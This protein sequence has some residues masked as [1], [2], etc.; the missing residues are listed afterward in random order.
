MKNE[1]KETS[2]SNMK[3][4]P[5]DALNDWMPRQAYHGFLVGSAQVYLARFFVENKS[6]KGGIDDAIKARDFINQ[7]IDD[8]HNNPLD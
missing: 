1:I 2:Y 7:L 3:I 8:L 5:W 4:Q 6:G